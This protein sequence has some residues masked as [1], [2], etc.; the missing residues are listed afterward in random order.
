MIEIIET[1]A[2]PNPVGSY[3][4][5]VRVNGLIF[6][7]GQIPIAPDTGH[8]VEGGITHQTRQVMKNLCAILNAAGSGPGKVVKTTVFLANLDDFPEF[9]QIYEEYFGAIRPARATVQVA[10]LPKEVLLE[11]E[12]V[13]VT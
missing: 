4:Q 8:V 3:S 7:S 10:R 1:K 2:A 12:A 9:N 5:A 6:V 13:A 11:V